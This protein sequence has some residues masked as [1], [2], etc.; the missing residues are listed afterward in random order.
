MRSKTLVSLALLAFFG[1]G[2][3]QRIRASATQSLVMT[4]EQLSVYAQFERAFEAR[5]QAIEQLYGIEFDQHWKPTIKFEIPI[6]THPALEGV[7]FAA[8]YELTRQGFTLN[9]GYF[10]HVR[11]NRRLLDYCIINQP[12]KSNPEL[13]LELR[14]TITHELAHALA[15]QLSRRL[16]F[17][18][19]PS[20]GYGSGDHQNEIASDMLCEGIARYVERDGPEDVSPSIGLIPVVFDES[21]WSD[22]AMRISLIY[23]GGHWLVY[24]VIKRFGLRS[25]L[26]YFFGHP[27]RLTSGQ[28]RAEAV[29]YQQRA[30]REL[31]LPA[32]RRK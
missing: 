20:I 7:A 16:G 25:A 30:L 31:E 17:G 29:A 13:S 5:M 10:E 23:N 8:H 26:C 11:E 15:D 22:R 14:N 1:M 3:S 18:T 19:F 12:D 4:G 28:L 6:V 24:P 32:P 2:C 9:P 27:F 21:C